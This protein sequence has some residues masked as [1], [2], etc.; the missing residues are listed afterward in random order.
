MKATVIKMI[1][2][3]NLNKSQY[4]PNS[5]QIE[6]TETQTDTRLKMNFLTIIGPITMF[7]YTATFSVINEY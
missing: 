2:L 4:N 3:N 5:Y 1:L 7:Q 6:G